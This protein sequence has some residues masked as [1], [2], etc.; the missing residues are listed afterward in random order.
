MPG[1]APG[2]TGDLAELIAGVLR[3][4]G[5]AP[6]ASERGVFVGP[7][8][9]S[10]LAAHLARGATLAHATLLVTTAAGSPVQAFLSPPPR[11][12]VSH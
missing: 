7:A 8:K 5:L 6:V 11:R 10:G 1:R 3:R 9:L 2:L 4:L 12:T